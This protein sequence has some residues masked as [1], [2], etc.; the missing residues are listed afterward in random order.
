M[1][2][3]FRM[4]DRLAGGSLVDR[5]REMRAEDLSYDEI[6]RRLFAAYGIEVTRQTLSNWCE[7]LG[8]TE[9]VQA[10]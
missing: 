6:G 3:T 2:A 5:L 4:A 1:T 9:A 7:Q 10:S 8:I